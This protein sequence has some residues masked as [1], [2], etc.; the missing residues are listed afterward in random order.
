M[1]SLKI[2]HISLTF[3]PMVSGIS[4]VITSVCD[5]LAERGH[6]V[7][8][9]TGTIKKTHFITENEKMHDDNQYNFV[10]KRF[11]C[12]SLPILA[13][14]DFS[15]K[16]GEYLETKDFDVVH[17]HSPLILPP[18]GDHRF[19][20]TMHAL[21]KPW[22]QRS[23]HSLSI[24]SN[25]RNLDW[26]TI[27]V[28]LTSKII[29]RFEKKCVSEAEKVI[30]VSK[31]TED[32]VREVYGRKEDYFEVVYNGL[33]PNIFT[34]V[35]SESKIKKKNYVLYVGLFM[36]IKG[37]EDILKVAKI[38]NDID[39]VLVGTGPAYNKYKSMSNKLGLDNV[40]MPGGMSKYELLTVYR[41]AK[42]F[43][44]PTYY[45]NCPMSI[46][47]S[48]FL[49][50]PILSTNVG[51][52]PELIT[53]GVEG[54][55]VPPG[56]IDAMVMWIQR[57]VDDECMQRRLAKAAKERANKEFTIEKTVDKLLKVYNE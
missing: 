28:L 33:D 9:L 41:E 29:S 40:S 46:L 47:E 10:V 36:S 27:S 19:F 51:G 6:E 54:I 5:E 3:P 17:L 18:K 37:I 8:V 49:G 16:V 44:L 43:F 34:T 39:F 32:I 14:L 38:L 7:E 1:E 4:T 15:K 22:L 12:A 21:V 2:C 52:I 53:N 13:Q 11:N 20:V 42:I 50:L 55:L 25:F 30:C 45:D 26:Y 23:G 56:D 31:V 57:L 35:D 24:V 48:M